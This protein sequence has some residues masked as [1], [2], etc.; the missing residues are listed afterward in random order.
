[1]AIKSFI[2]TWKLIPEATDYG[3]GKAPQ[4]GQY[5]ITHRGEQ[6]YLDVSWTDHEGQD[7]QLDFGLIPDGTEQPFADTKLA[8]SMR[9][10]FDGEKVLESWSSK[11]GHELV[12]VRRTLNEAGD[13]MQVIQDFNLPGGPKVKNI[14]TYQLSD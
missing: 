7:F 2:G 3:M 9:M 11:N 1:M 14:S 8:D 13:Q 12:H 5:L 6:I 4:K 10:S